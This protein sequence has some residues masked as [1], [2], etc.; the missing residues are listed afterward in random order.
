ML[1]TYALSAGYLRSL[2]RQSAEGAHAH[3]RDFSRAFE[4]TD[5]L[6][7]PTTPAPAFRLG[8]NADDPLQMYL[9]DIYTVSANLAG[10]PGLSL[11]CGMTRRRAADRNADPGLTLE[12]GDGPSGRACV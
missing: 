2:L 10:L 7:T 3:R 11:P 4:Q 6:L 12:R 5:I 1:G 8:E 9:A